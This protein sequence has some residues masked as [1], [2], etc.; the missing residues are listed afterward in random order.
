M[1]PTEILARQHFAALEPLAEAAG[2][3]MSV[4]TGRER[5]RTREQIL[6]AL[7]E[8]RIDILVGTHALFSE[9]VE[10]RDLGL[11]V[12]D[13]TNI[14]SACTNDSNSRAEARCRPTCSS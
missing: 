3:R 4:L 12:V 2:V 6:G 10:F 7:A 8:G 1:A 9:G 13:E 11:A 5:G 14:A